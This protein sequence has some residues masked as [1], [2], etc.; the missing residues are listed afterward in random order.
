[1]FI[2]FDFL[3][4]L[5]NHEIGEV[6]RINAD[7]DIKPLSVDYLIDLYFELKNKD[8]VVKDGEILLLKRR[9]VKKNVRTN[10]RSGSNRS[11]TAN[12]K[13]NK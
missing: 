4:F 7:P 3:H 11:G 9:G 5:E 10:S 13:A 1:M 8:L 12:K 6:I 2:D